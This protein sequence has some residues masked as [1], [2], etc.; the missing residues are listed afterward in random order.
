MAVPAIVSRETLTLRPQ[1]TMVGW[2]LNI[3]IPEDAGSHR[4]P[5]L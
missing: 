4:L 5:H 3:Q 1:P 2:G